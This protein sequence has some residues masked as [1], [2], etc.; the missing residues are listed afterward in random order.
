MRAFF[1]S[2]GKLIKVP[3][4]PNIKIEVLKYFHNLFLYDKDYTEKEVNDLLKEYYSDYVELRR[5][6]VDF[7]FL[8]RDEYGKIYRKNLQN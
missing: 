3:I 5:E 7:K 1:N 2:K 8:I 4:I 6:L